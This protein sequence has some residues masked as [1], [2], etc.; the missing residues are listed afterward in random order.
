LRSS[1][2][3]HHA[4]CLRQHGK[5]RPSVCGFSARRAEKPH[6]IGKERTALPQAQ[7]ANCVSPT[8]NDL[9]TKE[10]CRDATLPRPDGALACQWHSN[11]GAEH[12][13]RMTLECTNGQCYCAIAPRLRA[14]TWTRTT[15]KTATMASRARPDSE[16]SGYGKSM[17]DA[18]TS[19]GRWLR[20][21]RRMLDLT[22][23]ALARQA[24]CSVGAIRKIEAELFEVA[25]SK[26]VAR[27]QIEE[28][29]SA[30]PEVL[31]MPRGRKRVV[32]G[33]TLFDALEAPVSPS[34]TAERVPSPIRT[35]PAGV[36]LW[37]CSDPET[38]VRAAAQAIRAMGL[39]AELGHEKPR[40]VRYRQI[41]VIVPELDDAG[42]YQ[43]AIRRIFREHGIPFFI[44]QR[45]SMAHHPLVEFVRAAVC[46][47]T[48]GFDRDEA[49]GEGHP[50]GQ[51][52]RLPRRPD[53]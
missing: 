22:Q 5:Y 3:Q 24:V 1:A 34:P 8:H 41:A 46:V 6:T 39:S 21:R 37:Q 30:L 36:E 49:Q 25:I 23:E 47:V 40:Q 38:E 29:R 17:M 27:V 45:R 18:E 9:K 35:E 50:A 15:T 53:P 31:A 10:K 4:F 12:T 33:P 13:L 19:F 16:L 44:D 48:S 26:Q 11:P 42:G 14:Q 52:R 51:L 32:S 20:Q 28:R 2:S 43:D 7:H